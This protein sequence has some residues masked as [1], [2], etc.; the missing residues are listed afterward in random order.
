VENVLSFA[1]SEKGAERVTIAPTVVAREVEGAVELFLPL[2]RSRRMAVRVEVPHTLVAMA[3]GNALHQIVLNL[4]DNAAKYGP[5][6]QTITIRGAL[7]DGRVRLTI[8][9]AGPGIPE[10]ETARIWEPYVRLNREVESATGGSGIG[11]S[12]VRELVTMQHG[13]VA[14]DRSP[15]GGARFIVD[16]QPAD[17]AEGALVRAAHAAS[18]ASPQPT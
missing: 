12:V 2:A 16:L 9:D 11:L 1:R 10:A 8:D 14:V 18:A 5:P 7:H 4:L 15:A 6:G 13:T 17:D 3:D